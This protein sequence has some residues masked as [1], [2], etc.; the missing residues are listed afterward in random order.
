[1][2]APLEKEIETYN[3]LL[4]TLMSDEGKYALI[5]GN[6]LAG[7]YVAYEDALKAGYEKAK[8]EPF[9][10]KK[11]SGSEVIAYFSR[12]VDGPCRITPSP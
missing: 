10:V 1:M 5:V 7:V 11:I 4:P 12:D 3:R 8:L 2:T 6:D 9:L